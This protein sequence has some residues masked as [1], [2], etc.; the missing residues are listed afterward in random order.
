MFQDFAT[1]DAT[2]RV[3]ILRTGPACMHELVVGIVFRRKNCDRRLVSIHP[4]ERHD[5]TGYPYDPLLH[6][7]KNAGCDIAFLRPFWAIGDKS[8]NR[9]LRVSERIA[10]AMM[11]KGE[12]V[13]NAAISSFFVLELLPISL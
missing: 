8:R 6:A 11:K 12:V 9:S 4:P 10:Q 13:E 3:G 5:F 1:D 2:L 7:S